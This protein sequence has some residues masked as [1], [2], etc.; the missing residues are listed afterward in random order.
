M[1]WMPEFW[2]ERKDYDA[3]ESQLKYFDAWEFSIAGK[4]GVVLSAG[5]CNQPHYHLHEII[6]NVPHWILNSE[7]GGCSTCGEWGK[8]ISNYEPD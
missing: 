3:L 4:S 8:Q 2:I 6:R 1:P 5:E 7:G